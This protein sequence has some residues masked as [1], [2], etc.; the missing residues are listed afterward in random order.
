M[1]AVVGLGFASFGSDVV[2][3]AFGDWEKYVECSALA[4]GG[5][6]F[7]PALMLF[8]DAIDS[9]ET[10]ACAFVHLLGGEEGLENA[11]ARGAIHAASAVGN[12]KSE[13]FTGTRIGMVSALGIEADMGGRESD[14]AAAGHRIA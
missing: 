11:G 12:T 10:H 3:L 9:G 13:E 5:D 7:D 14:N 1:S 4:G 2:G 6:D 8:N